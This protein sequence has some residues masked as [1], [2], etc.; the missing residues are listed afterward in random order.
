VVLPAISRGENFTLAISTAGS[1]PAISR[2]IREF[3]EQELPEL[4]AM[5]ILQQRLRGELKRTEPDQL[6]R[7]AVLHKVLDDSLVWKLLKKDPEKAWEN[8]AV[9]YLHG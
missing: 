8:V 7:T 3:L 5:I 6:K 9:R 4:D 2:Y 1:S